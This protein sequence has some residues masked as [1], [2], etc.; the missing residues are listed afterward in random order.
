MNDKR[1]N[2]LI[3]YKRHVCGMYILNEIEKHLKKN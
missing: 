1:I 2:N 3:D